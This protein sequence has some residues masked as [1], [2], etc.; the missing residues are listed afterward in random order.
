MKCEIERMEIIYT[1]YFL[2]FWKK[3]IKN[4]V[5][6]AQRSRYLEIPR[7]APVEPRSA[8]YANGLNYILTNHRLTH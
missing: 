2:P 7:V 5:T 6:G 3:V 4:F 1:F 8:R